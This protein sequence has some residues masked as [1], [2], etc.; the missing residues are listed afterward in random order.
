MIANYGKEDSYICRTDSGHREVEPKNPHEEEDY[1]NTKKASKKLYNKKSKIV[2]KKLP[3][4]KAVLP[5][6]V[7]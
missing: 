7:I 5:R 4:N 2:V 3:V 6:K 1:L